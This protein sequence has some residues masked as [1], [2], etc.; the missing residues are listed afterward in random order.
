MELTLKNIQ[1][2]GFIFHSAGKHITTYKARKGYIL[3]I[4]PSLYNGEI[5][6]TMELYRNNLFNVIF[7]SRVE[8]ME[9]FETLMKLNKIWE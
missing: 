9:D 8:S 2:A 6:T 4:Y 5:N 3:Q 1:Q 7:K